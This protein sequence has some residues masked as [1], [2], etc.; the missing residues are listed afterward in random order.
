MW[1]G[2]RRKQLLSNNSAQRIPEAAKLF[3]G[4]DLRSGMAGKLCFH[5][6]S[7]RNTDSGTGGAQLPRF[8]YAGSLAWYAANYC[9]LGI[10]GSF[11]YHFRKETTLSRGSG[12]GSTHLGL[13]GRR[14]CSLYVAL[15]SILPV[16]DYVPRP[17]LRST[18]G[19][20]PRKLLMITLASP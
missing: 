11:Q 17:S 10:F 18:E 6:L 16:F 15:Q 4:L 12:H 3:Y 20:A 13:R 14:C 9:I 8:V 19:N 1:H 5:S 7:H 2:P